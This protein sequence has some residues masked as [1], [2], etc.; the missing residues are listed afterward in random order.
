[1]MC[2][3]VLLCLL[4]P[5]ALAAPDLDRYPAV[6]ELTLGSLP[7]EVRP[8]RYLVV[9]AP[10]SGLLQLHLP[11]PGERL[12]AGAVWAE[13][14]PARL[15]LE[16]EAVDLARQLFAAKDQPGLR[17]EQAR[18]RAELTDHLEELQRQSGMLRRM[19]KEPELAAL[20]LDAPD[21]GAG[22]DA[23]R[24]QMLQLDQQARLLRDVLQYVG[25][26]RQEELE[27]AALALKLRQQEAE[28]A[29]RE[30]ASRLTMPFAGEITLVPP[31]P[32]PGEA[33]A[34]ESGM[35]L[36]RLQDFSRVDARIVL[37]RAAWRLLE[38]TRLTL[39]VRVGDTHAPLRAIFR[40]SLTEEVFGREE[41]VYYF[42]FVPA[43]VAAARALA[44][45]QVGVELTASLPAPARLVP[46]LDLVLA[47]PAAF[48]EVGWAAGVARLFPGHH[49]VLAGE[50]HLA[51]AADPP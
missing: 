41:L 50:T 24:Y 28:L 23:V 5:A 7:A 25:T 8:A 45:G 21:G 32:A 47:D 4:A 10:S 40:R 12:E 43:D 36:A 19:L 30:R 39:V 3:L 14:E 15:Q 35:D 33:L 16:R 22:A 13:L 11:A 34:V 37:R 31:R 29:R 26:P 27:L 6:S 46:K 18:T 1:M 51:I 20:Y 38:P 44:G 42:S 17:Y 48:R 2:R 9:K 49:I